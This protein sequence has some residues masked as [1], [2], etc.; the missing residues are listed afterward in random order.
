MKFLRVLGR[1][2]LMLV[3]LVLA[4]GAGAWFWARPALPEAFFRSVTVPGAPGQLLAVEP[5]SRDVPDGAR[6][7]LILYSTTRIDGSPAVASA[8]VMAGENSTG[9][10]RSIAWA[11]GTTGIVPGCAPSVFAPFA[12]VP[13]LD[14]MLAAG[15]AYVATDYVGLGTEGGHA[16]L[17]GDDAARAVLDSLRAAR[18]MDEV[19]IAPQ[20]VVWGHSQG[21]HSA[22]WT[23]MRAADYA[24]ELDIRGVAGL[25]P[26]SAMPELIET[27]KGELF[28][29]VVSSY[30]MKSYSMFYDDVRVE[31]YVAWPQTWLANDMAGRCAGGMETVVSLAEAMLLPADGLFSTAPDE[32][33]LGARVRQNVPNGPY[34]MPVFVGQGGDDALVLPQVQAQ[35]ARTLCDDGVAVTYRQ[36]EG[37]DHLGLVAPGSELTAALM[38]WTRA[39]FD[40]TAAAGCSW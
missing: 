15:W 20:A 33:P 27:A 26:A 38:D 34:A 4:G 5:Y 16:Y 12:N 17:I 35:F 3:V 2:A 40:G 18:Q 39:R 22:L 1:L 36:Y 19:D 9:T 32:G 21:G 10:L 25:A 31:D 13:A 30:V 29:K 28:G 37:L 8:V 7:W 23:G 6:A 14:E 11:H 24:P